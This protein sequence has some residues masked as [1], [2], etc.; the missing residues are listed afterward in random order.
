LAS[1]GP[2]A[3]C[4]VQ[5]TGLFSSFRQYTATGMCTALNRG[6]HADSVLLTGH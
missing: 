3:H 4:A 6:F 1:N 5:Q 2:R